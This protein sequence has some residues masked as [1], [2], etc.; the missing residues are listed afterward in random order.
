ML[1]PAPQAAQ[2]EAELAARAAACVDACHV[3][4]VFADSKFLVR[5]G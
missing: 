4:E 3:D 2:R 1:S 5:P